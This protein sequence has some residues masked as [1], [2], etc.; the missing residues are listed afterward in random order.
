MPVSFDYAPESDPGPY[1]VPSDAPIE[2]GTASNGDRHVLVIDRDNW[3]L[4]ELFDAH[5]VDGGAR[6]QAGSDA[7]YGSGAPDARWDDDEIG[8]LK[9]VPSSAFEVVRMGTVITG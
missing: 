1:P 9:R 6:W 2:G 3:K 8:A 5:P 7:I 4:Y